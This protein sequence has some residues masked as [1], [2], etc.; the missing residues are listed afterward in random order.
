MP[1]QTVDDRVYRA[2]K[3]G[4]EFPEKG[5]DGTFPWRSE[6]SWL[7]GPVGYE[8]TNIAGSIGYGDHGHFRKIP[9]LSVTS[10]TCLRGVRTKP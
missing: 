8:P 4:K 10:Q 6:K 1:I 2:A 3:V 7:V 5:C 9:T